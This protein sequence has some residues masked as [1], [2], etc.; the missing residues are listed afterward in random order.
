MIFDLTK[1]AYLYENLSPNFAKAFTYL[2]S[3]DLMTM[4]PGRY[5]ID[6]KNVYLNIQDAALLTAET[7]KWE[8][9]RSYADIQTDL[10]GSEIIG[11]RPADALT[12]TEPYDAEKDIA[13]FGA[14]DG[15]LRV[16]LTGRDFVVLFPDD[17]HQ[18]CVTDGDGGA[19]RKA[20]FKVRL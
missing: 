18:P 4:A 11:V 2:A 3:H 10:T 17:A 19:V 6:G 16:R 9:H 8:A 13:F 15:G 20:V 7:A 5:E 14:G 1:N 12:E